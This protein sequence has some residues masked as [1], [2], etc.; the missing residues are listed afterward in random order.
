MPT[1]SIRIDSYY[2]DDGK[3]SSTGRDL[4][5]DKLRVE[6]VAFLTPSGDRV[7]VAMNQGETTVKV[8]IMDPQN[9]T[10]KQNDEKNTIKDERRRVASLELAPN[11]IITALWR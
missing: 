11:S 10:D 7:F 5:G 1:G 9:P 8:R 4:D 2:S 3:T 6:H